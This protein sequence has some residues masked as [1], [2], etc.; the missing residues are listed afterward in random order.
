MTFLAVRG[1]SRFLEETTGLA[2]GFTR[3]IIKSEYVCHGLLSSHAHFC[4][5][6]IT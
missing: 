6:R 1:T 3:L 2:S 4:I 5:I